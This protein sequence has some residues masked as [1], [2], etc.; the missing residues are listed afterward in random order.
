MKLPSD[1][2]VVSELL[3]LLLLE[4]LEATLIFSTLSTIVSS[5]VLPRRVMEASARRSVAGRSAGRGGVLSCGTLAEG[6]AATAEGIV[7]RREATVSAVPLLVGADA[8]MAEMDGR[9]C[10]EL[11]RATDPLSS[12]CLRPGEF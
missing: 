3:P 5:I 12:A 8:A 4:A 7:R 11:R 9:R 6:G 1:M 10:S 2:T